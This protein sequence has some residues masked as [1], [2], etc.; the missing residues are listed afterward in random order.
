LRQHHESAE[1]EKSQRLVTLLG[2]DGKTIS[3]ALCRRRGSICLDIPFYRT[4]LSEYGNL[5]TFRSKSHIARRRLIKRNPIISEG[6]LSL[7]FV[8]SHANLV[9]HADP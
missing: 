7:P 9:Y 1:K 4:G 6:M 8:G 3:F 5:G 2:L